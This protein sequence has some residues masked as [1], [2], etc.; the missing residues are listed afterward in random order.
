MA[1]QL[2]GQRMLLAGADIRAATFS[3]LQRLIVDHDGR[4]DLYRAELSPA[5]A[6]RAEAREP[7]V[8]AAVDGARDL[9]AR[10]M[11][12]AHA[13]NVEL[14]RAD[15][16]SKAAAVTQRWENKLE[17]YEWVFKANNFRTREQVEAREVL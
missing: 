15:A 8:Q 11:L 10:T 16:E 4:A 5:E 6:Q 14:G 9:F 7:A 2:D 17:S 3:S 1:E 13:A 12:D